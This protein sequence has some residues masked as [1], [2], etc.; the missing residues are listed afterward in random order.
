MKGR[1]NALSGSRLSFVAYLLIST[2][3]GAQI[4]AANTTGDTYSGTA[5]STGSLVLTVYNFGLYTITAVITGES[6]TVAVVENGHSYNV[7]ITAWNGQLYDTGNEYTFKTGGWVADDG[8][9]Y[10]GYMR[11]KPTVQKLE[12]KMI[13][14][15]NGPTKIGAFLTTNTI[16]I[17]NFTK[18]YVTCSADYY[19]NVSQY[20]GMNE[21]YLLDAFG[22][23]AVPTSFSIDNTKNYTLDAN[24]NGYSGEYQVGFNIRSY[25]YI[26]QSIFQELTLYKVWLE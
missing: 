10:S 7:T 12:D 26:N 23:Y 20:D 11:V 6:T 16:D 15:V 8:R 22:Q 5:D 9:P 2:D 21:F 3:A 4:S 14:R 13:V 18:M 25:D 24:I 1:V 19:V 17:T